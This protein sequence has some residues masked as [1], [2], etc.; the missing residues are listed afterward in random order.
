VHRVTAAPTAA[1]VRSLS[2]ART[3]RRAVVRWRSADPRVLGFD[4][5][6]ATSR[7]RERLNRTLLPRGARAFVDR[8]GAASARRYWL[9]VT[10]LD[11]TRRWYGPA[12][13]N[14]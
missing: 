4:V 6:R 3:D 14:T 9:R 1:L 5:Y 2:V 7:G 12:V 11:G 10:L 13:A 8:G